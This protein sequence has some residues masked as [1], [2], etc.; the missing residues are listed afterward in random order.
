MNKKTTGYFLLALAIGIVIFQYVKYR[1]APHFELNELQ[2]QTADQ[3]NYSIQTKENKLTVV[4]FF[5][6]WC[7]SC[8]RDFA[9]I[10]KAKYNKRLNNVEF[11]AITDEPFEKLT[12]YIYNYR[13]E[14]IDFVHLAESMSSIGVHAYPTIYIFNSKGKMLFSKVGLVNWNDAEWLAQFKA[15]T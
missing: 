15:Q 8:H 7:G 5:T 1:V 13:Y 11:V 12:N 9:D 4:I 2:L 14:H 6:T 3:K 10:Q